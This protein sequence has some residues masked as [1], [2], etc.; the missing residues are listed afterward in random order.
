MNP[1]GYP[2]LRAGISVI[3]EERFLSGLKSAGIDLISLW[4]T[5]AYARRRDADIEAWIAQR[6]TTDRHPGDQA[7]VERQMRGLSLPEREPVIVGGRPTITAL[8]PRILSREGRE[9]AGNG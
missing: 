1:S 3:D 5:D 6:Q 9:N 2:I 7:L 4:D 8:A